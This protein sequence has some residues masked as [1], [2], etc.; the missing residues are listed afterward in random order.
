[1]MFHVVSNGCE[2]TSFVGMCFYI[3]CHD[4]S[5][6]TDTKMRLLEDALLT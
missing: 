3:S 2:V 5:V 1:M 6:I 4:A